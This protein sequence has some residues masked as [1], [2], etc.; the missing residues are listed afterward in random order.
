MIL[1]LGV[2]I[3]WCTTGCQ[4]TSDAVRVTE[5]VTE[6]VQKVT[7]GEDIEQLFAYDRRYKVQN[8]R[9]QQNGVSQRTAVATSVD[10]MKSLDL[11]SY[12]REIRSAYSGHQ[13]AWNEYHRALETGKSR[14]EERA[15]QDMERTWQRMRQ[16]AREYG[17]STSVDPH[18]YPGETT[19]T[20]IA[21]EVSESV[22]DYLSG[23]DINLK[24]Y[25]DDRMV[26]NRSGENARILQPNCTLQL[27]PSS[28]VSIKVV[29][30]DIQN[31]DSVASWE[32]T[33]AEL[34]QQSTFSFGN[35]ESMRLQ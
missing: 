25:K 26:C 5:T 4:S 1:L 14:D 30:E 21:I 9:H 35:V 17:A 32:T 24:V 20:I 8:E 7:A 28:R 10:S 22:G 11:G 23:P 27:G 18:V 13:E 6:A 34:T 19:R 15:T 12:P 31:D 3:S 29:E 16:L 33:G 2:A